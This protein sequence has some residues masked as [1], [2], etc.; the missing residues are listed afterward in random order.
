MSCVVVIGCCIRRQVR[1][2]LSLSLTPGAR[3]MQNGNTANKAVLGDG[4]SRVETKLAYYRDIVTDP[5]LTV[6]IIFFSGAPCHTMCS[7][8]GHDE[9]FAHAE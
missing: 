8:D 5:C 3:M 4:T 6:A 7:G 9:V 1:T 2:A